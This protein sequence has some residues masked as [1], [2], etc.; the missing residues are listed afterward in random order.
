MSKLLK[1]SLST[2][3]LL[4]TASFHSAQAFEPVPIDEFFKRY[5]DEKGDV[6]DFFKDSEEKIISP[7]DVVGDI[8]KESMKNK[9]PA[10]RE[11]KKVKPRKTKVKVE[12][13]NNIQLLVLNRIS[14]ERQVV[15]FA[16]GGEKYID[17]FRIIV[18]SCQKRI[19]NSANQYTAVAFRVFDQKKAHLSPLQQGEENVQK[20]TPKETKD[21]L[22]FSNHIY[23]E[24]PGVNAFEHPIYDIRPLSCS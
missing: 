24:L 15:G 3:I 13:M 19:V 7:K 16:A 4:L 23:V 21:N 12:K 18:S 20:N 14:G 17:H 10:L 9:G 1:Q 22:I 11:P 6:Q 5:P 8:I 2:I